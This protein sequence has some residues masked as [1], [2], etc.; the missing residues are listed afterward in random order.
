[1]VSGS[2]V[3]AAARRAP[4]GSELEHLEHQRAAHHLL[5]VL[6]RQVG[7]RRP[8]HPVGAGAL[9]HQ[10]HQIH[11]RHLHL[12][13]IAHEQEAILLQHCFARGLH[14]G[15][16]QIGPQIHRLVNRAV[17]ARPLGGRL[18]AGCVADHAGLAAGVFQFRDRN[19]LT[20]GRPRSRWSFLT[21]SGPTSFAAPAR[22]SEV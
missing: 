18:E 8:E 3:V 19:H 12:V 13:V 21:T 4:V 16:V 11:V 9:Q 15:G 5:A 22:P 20:R 10:V 14:G 6:D 1:M 17:I 7:A 2:E